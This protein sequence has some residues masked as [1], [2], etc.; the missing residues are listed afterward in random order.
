MCIRSSH[1]NPKAVRIAEEN[2]VILF[3]LVPHTIHEMQPLDTAG[4]F[5][6]LVY[7]RL[8][9]MKFVTSIFKPILDWQLLKTNLVPSCQRHG[10]TLRCH[11][12]SSVVLWN[13]SLQSKSC[14]R[15]WPFWHLSTEKEESRLGK[16]TDSEHGTGTWLCSN[17]Y[18]HWLCFTWQKCCCFHRRGT[19]IL[20]KTRWRIWLTCIWWTLSSLAE[21]KLFVESLQRSV[22]VAQ[23]FNDMFP[24]TPVIIPE[25]EH[26]NESSPSE[27]N[28]RKCM[29]T[30][31]CTQMDNGNVIET[32]TPVLATVPTGSGTST[33]SSV[34]SSISDAS[35]NLSKY[36][37]QYVPVTPKSRQ[38]S[39]SRVCGTRVLTGSN[40][41]AMLKEKE[42]KK[43][44]EF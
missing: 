21:S 35:D 36:L 34:G 5:L 2:D 1:H 40:G 43:K 29:T 31:I 28:T 10:W 37:I 3:T 17:G 12:Q 26:H 19:L 42:C 32:S 23:Y 33:A 27:P 14:S 18:W 11:Q 30:P 8:T 13:I 6:F 20:K 9:D 38:P 15:L 41:L 44:R 16:G 22:S 39:D 7:S 4:L 24:C 25:L